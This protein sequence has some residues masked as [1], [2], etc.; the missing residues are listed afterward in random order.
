MRTGWNSARGILADALRFFFRHYTV[1]LAF[2][3]L[4][5]AQRFLAVGGDERWAWTGGLGGELFTNAIRLL[6]AVWVVRTMFRPLDVSWSD[7]GRRFGRY[8]SDHTPTLLWSGAVLVGLTLV[9]KVGVDAWIAGLAEPRTAL[10]WTLAIKNV[11]IIPFMIVWGTALAR[12]AVT[13]PV[14]HTE[15]LATTKVSN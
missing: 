7:A 8:V 10:A 9:F 3:L 14:A 13:E 1:V 12:E 5:S 11:S 6:F 2:G 15:P 4:A